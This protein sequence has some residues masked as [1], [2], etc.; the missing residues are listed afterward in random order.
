MKRSA[1]DL[2]VL[3]ALNQFNDLAEGCVFTDT[4]SNNLY[5]AVAPDGT[6]HQFVR[7]IKRQQNRF[8]CN[9]SL[10]N[11]PTPDNTVPS[12]GTLTCLDKQYITDVNALVDV[13]FF[14]FTVFH[15]L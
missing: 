1:A 4:V 2:R 5:G 12:T 10:I 11:L 8:A 9:T 15:E 3:G 13:N 7:A 6:L 14:K